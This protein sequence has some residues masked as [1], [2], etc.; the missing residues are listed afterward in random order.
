MNCPFLLWQEAVKKICSW[1]YVNCVDMWVRFISANIRDFDLQSLFFMTVKLI[2]GV[3]HMFP[4][5]RYLPLRLKSIEWLNC[6]SSSSGTFIPVASLVLDILEYKVAGEG[7]KAQIAFDT[8]SVLKVRI[9][10]ILSHAVNLLSFS[11]QFNAI[12]GSCYLVIGNWHLQLPKH[13][14]KS[15]SFQDECFQS[16]V[17]QLAF[18]FSQWSFH[19][20]FPD[21][22]TIPLIRLRRILDITTLESLRRIVKRMID[23]VLVL[24]ASSRFYLVSFIRM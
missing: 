12:F 15:K 17:K 11:S 14:L 8:A 22:A 6:L 18:H 1:E 4:G 9:M 19:I 13:Y 23:Q 20:S 21:L 10:F 3:A 2:N 5:P 24:L 16:A 7:R